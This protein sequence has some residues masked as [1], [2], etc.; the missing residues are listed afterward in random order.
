MDPISE[1]IDAAVGDLDRQT[2]LARATR[3][4]QGYQP[5]R[6]QELHQLIKLALATHKASDLRRQV[7]LSLL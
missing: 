4:S 3:P 5:A 6:A 7:E 2:R 1:G